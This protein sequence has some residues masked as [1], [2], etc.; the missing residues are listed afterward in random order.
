MTD[1]Q[2][3]LTSLEEVF[4]TIARKAEMEAAA[5]QGR[6]TVHWLLED[7]R[8]LEVRRAGGR[9]HTGVAGCPISRPCSLCCC[10][11]W[12]RRAPLHCAAACC[13]DP[14]WC[15]PLALLLC[16]V[17]MGEDEAQLDGQTWRIKW[18]QDE[19]GALQ[20]MSATPVEAPAPAPAG[21]GLPGG[22]SSPNGSGP[23]VA[24]PQAV[25]MARKD[26]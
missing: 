22:S 4:L 10:C 8:Q 6:H 23:Q 14:C 1:V 17:G 5:A 12:S 11:A 26:A 16:Q 18:T 9:A 7:G 20:I 15:P 21:G 3:G 19:H 13:A 2:I 24:P 25:E